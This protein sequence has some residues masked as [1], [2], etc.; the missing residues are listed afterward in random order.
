MIITVYRR[1]V[2]S[3]FLLHEPFELCWQLPVLLPAFIVSLF[4]V[5]GQLLK[6]VEWILDNFCC[7]CWFA[8]FPKLVTGHFCSSGSLWLCCCVVLPGIWL[9]ATL[10]TFLPNLADIQDLLHCSSRNTFSQTLDRMKCEMNE[11]QSFLKFWMRLDRDIIWDNNINSR[12]LKAK[13]IREVRNRWQVSVFVEFCVLSMQCVFA[14]HTSVA[15]INDKFPIIINDWGG[16]YN[17]H[18]L[19]S[20]R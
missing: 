15:I 4:V 16:L 6:C 9:L 3:G 1:K 17:G 12:Y 10:R 5:A 20:V 7:V 14:S 19:F 8:G 11:M 13:W 2:R 18:W